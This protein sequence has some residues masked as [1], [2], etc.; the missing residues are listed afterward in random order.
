MER[1]P[2]SSAVWQALSYAWQ[3]GYTV[4]VPLVVFAVG[5]RYLDR[6]LGTKPWLFLAGL[7]IA[8]VLSMV[9]LI[10][11]AISIFRSAGASTRQ[12]TSEQDTA[13]KKTT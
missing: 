4:A 7:L 6:V 3:F 2:Q 9:G 10:R 5:G 1:S 12:T 11:K 8:I 13:Q